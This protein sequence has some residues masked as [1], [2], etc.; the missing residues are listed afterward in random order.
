[1]PP[2]LD[3]SQTDSWFRDLINANCTTAGNDRMC[4][5]RRIC[6]SCQAESHRD[7]YY[8]RLTGLPPMGDN[9]DAGEVYFIDTFMNNWFDNINGVKFNVMGADFTLHSTYED[10]LTGEN[11]WLFCN[12]NDPN[13]GFPRDCGPDT[14]QPH[15]WNSYRRGDGHA[16]HHGF[17]VEVPSN[18]VQRKARYLSETN[19]IQTVSRVPALTKS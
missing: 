12:Y 14:H 7:I 18:D 17:F 13:I 16:N 15:E 11:P 5:I 4:I 6:D 8:R 19:S 1:M 10:S 2:E 9:I 3:L